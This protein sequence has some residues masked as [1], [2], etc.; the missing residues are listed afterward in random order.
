MLSPETIN[1]LSDAARHVEL[2]MHGDRSEEIIKDTFVAAYQ[3][4]MLAY[5][6][7]KNF[8]LAVVQSAGDDFDLLRPAAVYVIAKFRIPIKVR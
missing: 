7:Q 2:L 6:W 1:T 3:S 8:A 4:G 5:A